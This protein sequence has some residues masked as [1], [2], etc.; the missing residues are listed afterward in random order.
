MQIDNIIIT[1]SVQDI[2]SELKSQL[3]LNGVSL[4]AKIFDSGDN[5]MVCCPYHKNGQEKKPSAGFRK[6]DGFFHCL[7]CGESHQ[8]HEVI[9]HCF[10]KEDFGVY[11]LTWLKQNFLSVGVEN[12]EHLN[13]SFSRAINTPNGGTS[14]DTDSDDNRSNYVT[15]EEL[16]K[17]RYTHPYMYERGL[18]DGIINF[19]DI[20]Y[21]TVSRSITFPVKDI[22]GNC[23]F[24]ARR[25]VSTKRF[26]LPKGIDKPLYGL[27]EVNLF[28]RQQIGRGQPNRIVGV[29]E[30]Y[31]CEGLFD[32]LRLWCN[33]KVAVA[34]FGC[35]FSDYQIN[36]LKQLPT[37]RLVLAT[38]NDDAGMS[39]RRKLRKALW[40]KKLISEVIIPNGHKDIGECT[41]DEIQHLKEI[42]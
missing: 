38:D 35:L 27:Y 2:I 36:Q 9:S 29:P 25:A 34:G 21:D 17:Y 22:N 28:A 3:A 15:E 16:D 10:G 7:A 33:G 40:G 1:Q 31:I 23:L 24:V 5:V 39:A 13:L 20:G 37:R 26:D 4:F 19:F 14:I 32:C 11:G 18:T 6:S 42:F 8:L 12:R 30:V 41:D